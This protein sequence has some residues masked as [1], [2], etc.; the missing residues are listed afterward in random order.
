MKFK[1]GIVAFLAAFM[2]FSQGASEYR[3]LS[4][5]LENDVV[6]GTDEDYTNGF[7]LSYISP[8]IETLNLPE[9]AYQVGKN[10]PL[11]HH[12]G[13][14]NNVGFSVG[15]LMFTPSDIR[16]PNLRPEERPYAGWLYGSM[17]L[18]HKNDKILH[19]LELTLGVV[20]PS[21]YAEATQREVHGW[22]NSTLPQGWDN[23]LHD[24]AG[25]ILSYEQKRRFATGT[26]ADLIP[27]VTLNVGNILTSATVGVT[28]RYGFNLP[29]DF[30]SNRISS[31]GYAQ[32]T[33]R[34]IKVKKLR[35]FVFT[36]LSGHA[37]Q[38]NI[39]LDGNTDGDGHSVDK[40]NYVGELEIG[41]GLGYRKYS[42]TYTQV[43]KSREY[44]GQDHGT[45]FGSISLSYLF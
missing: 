45:Q 19:K 17:S 21:S 44:D 16:D 41:A 28:A 25:V 32:A 30:H 3:N 6:G 8:D 2:C 1:L 31:S 5:H 12:D 23:Q 10:I 24:E 39:F 38:K 22:T 43:F 42:L 40:E 34:D 7:K 36:S 13:Y 27:H 35:A 26:Y 15:Q 11:F 4:L 18:H 37:I 33:D 29:K 9:W 20:G 14:T